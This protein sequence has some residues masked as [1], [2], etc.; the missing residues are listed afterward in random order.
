M[1][2]SVLLP[3]LRNPGNDRALQVALRMLEENTDSD[4]ILCL[5]TTKS[6]PLI[7]RMNKL[8]EQSPTEICVF[9]SS[10]IFLAPHWD[11][12][13]M[14]AYALDTIVTGV[15]V[16][17]GV[18]GVHEMNYGY[19][20]GVTPETFKRD[21]FER[22]AEKEVPTLA[23]DGW[24]VPYMFHRDRW[25]ALGGLSDDQGD[26]LVTPAD[27]RYF[28]QWKVAG[29]KIV[30]T[31]SCAYHLQRWSDIGEQEAGKRR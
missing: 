1:I 8:V 20:F 31:K 15:V 6:D 17:P 27:E 5:D 14:D 28:Q 26:L 7:P 13:M 29:N 18:M 3:H 9:T 12:L 25:L 24:V 4:Y 19:N 10:D 16:E 30:R 22:F 2:F 21:R 11:T 23:G